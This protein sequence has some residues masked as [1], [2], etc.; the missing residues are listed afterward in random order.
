MIFD[1]LACLA[2]ATNLEAPPISFSNPAEQT[3]VSASYPTRSIPRKLGLE[4]LDPALITVISLF[5]I[6]LHRLDAIV[7]C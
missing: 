3:S 6:K 5:S 1:N 2:E 4:L 7:N